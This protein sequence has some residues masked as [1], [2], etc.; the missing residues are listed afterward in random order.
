MD[1]FS[2]PLAQTYL[3]KNPNTRKAL[4][5]KS[6][7]EPPCAK[8]YVCAERPE[9][10]LR[11]NLDTAT[12]LLLQDKVLRGKLGMLSPDVMCGGR[13]VSNAK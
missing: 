10:T 2:F 11:I 3:W 8:C 6:K 12:L 1:V 9:V 13:C 7:L 4:L 5:I